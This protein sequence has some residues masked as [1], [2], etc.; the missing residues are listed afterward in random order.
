MHSARGNFRGLRLVA[1]ALLVMTATAG[2]AQYAFADPS[3]PAPR[4][5]TQTA[6]AVAR[7][8]GDVA[9]NVFRVALQALVTRNVITQPQADAVQRQVLAGSVYPETLVAEGTLS[10]DQM[11]QVVNS[12]AAV[13]R[14]FADASTPTEHDPTQTAGASVGPH[15]DITQDAYRALEALATRKIITQSQAD[16]VQRQVLAGS[17]DPKALVDAGILSND[18][19]RQVANSLA[20]VKRAG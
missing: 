18:Q 1:G 3:T 2:A 19:M 4:D 15:R 16:A 9:Q 7:P 11:R 5:P 14:A 20:A 10:D 17:V 13:K 6:A 12:L 8:Q